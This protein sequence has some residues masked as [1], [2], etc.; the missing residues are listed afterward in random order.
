MKTPW[1]VNIIT[2]PLQVDFL[3]CPPRTTQ[4]G[5]RVNAKDFQKRTKGMAVRIVTMSETLPSTRSAD[6][7]AHQILRSAT[8]VAA[9]YRAACVAKSRR[10]MINKLRI[11]REEADETL[12]WLEIITE[13]KMLPENSLHSLKDEVDQI[14]RMIVASI[15]TMSCNEHNPKSKV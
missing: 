8:S 11:V 9:N 7:V 10:D 14:L 12:F 15:R 3:F 5:A 6:V 2:P 13:T 1:L 4:G